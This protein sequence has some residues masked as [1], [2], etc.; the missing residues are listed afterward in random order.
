MHRVVAVVARALVVDV[1]LLAVGL[2]RLAGRG[3]VVA[4]EAVGA[5]GVARLSG[6]RDR[7][8]HALHAGAFGV[9]TV[10]ARALVVLRAGAPVRHLRCDGGVTR[11][12]AGWL[13][14]TSYR[15]GV[16]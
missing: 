8:A 16:V 9:D 11:N 4:V 10:V 13:A 5:A 15:R 14:G 6:G 3:S 2:L 1:A 7:L 12:Q